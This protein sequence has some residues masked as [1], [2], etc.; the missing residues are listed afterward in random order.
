[1]TPSWE[2]LP[3][4][5]VADPPPPPS[6]R[7]AV[8]AGAGEVEWSRYQPKQ[9]VRCDDCM[10]AYIEDSAA[11]LARQAR[12]QRRQGSVRRLLCTGHAKEWRDYDNQQKR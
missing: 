12:Y 11:P 1:M 7:K 6:V 3:L 4:F 8:P 10:Q 9:P 5:E 2:E